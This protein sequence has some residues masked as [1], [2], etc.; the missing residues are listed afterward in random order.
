M[1]RMI[2]AVLENIG[3]IVSPRL[4]YHHRSCSPCGTDDFDVCIDELDVFGDSLSRVGIAQ[5]FSLATSN[6][7]LFSN[8]ILNPFNDMEI[9]FCISHLWIPLKL[10]GEFCNFNSQFSNVIEVGS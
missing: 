4:G 3:F 9:V 10:K 1:P 8:H 7:N 5:H 2:T 6:L